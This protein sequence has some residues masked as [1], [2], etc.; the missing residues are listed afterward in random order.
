MPRFTRLLRPV[1][2]LWLILCAVPV[3]AQIS[4]KFDGLVV[5]AAGKIDPATKAQL[6]QKLQALQKDTG[7]QLV[8][9]TIPDLRGRPIEDYGNK[10]IRYWGVGLKDV[11]NGAILFVAPNEGK[12]QRGPRLE[13]GYGLEPILTDAWSS[14]M[15]RTLM[16]PRLRESSD[17]SGALNAGA[18]AVITQLRASPEEA[19]A[20]VTEAAKQFDHQNRR[21]G[22]DSDGFP[23]LIVLVIFI[24]G[25][26]LLSI[27]RRRQGQRFHD[28]DDDDRGGGGGRRGGG[29]WPII[30]WGPGWGSG[31][32]SGGGW[33]SGGSDG[34][35]DGSW[36]GG[37]FTGGGGGSGGGGG[38]SGDW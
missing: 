25:F 29:G 24:G 18:D 2:G 6:E 31:G 15:I 27:L 16:L 19:K 20:R 7:R 34:G 33:S 14:Q 32:G 36:F 5:D 37:G 9:A 3:M 21:G 38:A 17:I 4:P 26:V 1:L 23:I 12:G 10:L 13:V 11:N 8:V 28:D 35:S 22:G 30:L